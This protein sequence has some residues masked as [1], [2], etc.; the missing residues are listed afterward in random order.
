MSYPPRGYESTDKRSRTVTYN[1]A[2]RP[3]DKVMTVVNQA[4]IDATDVT[5]TITTCT[6]PCTVTGLR[7]NFTVNQDGG[8][9]LAHIVWAIIYLREGETID[10]LTFSDGLT[11]YKPESSVLVWGYAG[12]SNSTEVKIIEGTTKTMR[13][14]QLGDAIHMIFRGVATNTSHIRGAVQLFLKG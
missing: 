11:F 4:A 10:G 7:W 13:K 2:K 1:Q 8:T 6:Y 12:I 3:I 5:S 9:G 14:M